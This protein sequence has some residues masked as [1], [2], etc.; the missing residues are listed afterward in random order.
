MRC[1]IWFW[2]LT[3]IKICFQSK[4]STF[5]NDD[6]VFLNSTLN[7]S[8][9]MNETLFVSPFLLINS[10]VI[11]DRENKLK[12]KNDCTFEDCVLK[13]DD[14]N[15]CSASVS[16]NFDFDF[17]FIFSWRSSSSASLSDSLRSSKFE[18]SSF[19]LTFEKC[20]ARSID[21][22]MFDWYFE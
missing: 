15:T 14:D 22:N 13:N 8:M 18:K 5:N 20:H 3:S 17:L 1:K 19:S 10:N 16:L 6:E 12:Y 9:S 11:D 21:E 7:M 4:C 2:F